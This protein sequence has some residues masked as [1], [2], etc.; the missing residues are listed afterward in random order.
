MNSALQ[1]PFQFECPL[2]VF[3]KAGAEKGKERRFGGMVSTQRRDRQQEKILQDG[4]D[5]SEF[6]SNGWFNDNHSKLT[7]GIVGYPTSVERRTYKGHP[8][9]YVEGYLLQGYKPADDIWNLAESLQKTNRRLGFSVEGDVTQRVYDGR[10]IA[11][12]KVR[13]VAITN[14]PVNTDTGLEIL[15]KSMLA[16]ETAPSTDEWMQR[17]LAAGQAINNPG[18]SPGEGFPLRVERAGPLKKDQLTRK[19]ALQIIQQRYPGISKQDAYRLL[20][21]VINIL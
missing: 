12:A 13:N 15:A 3:Y 11:K 2:E 4:L 6:I 1:I 14:C 9:H 10:T 7:T 21:G 17:A 18:P 20:D 19:K 5:F 16:L 8:G